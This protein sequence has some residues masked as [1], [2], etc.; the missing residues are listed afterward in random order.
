MKNVS[1]KSIRRLLGSSLKSENGAATVEFVLWVPVMA[2]LLGLVIDTSLVFGARSQI[3]R[4]VQDTNRAV[5]VGRIRS[6]AE[7]E[8]ILLLNIATIAPNALAETTMTAGII[9]STVTIPISD[10]T[11]TGL[12]NSFNGFVVTVTS[13]HLAES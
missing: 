1:V 4:V 12:V 11:A 6:P 13:Q 3:L 2:A 9:S 10:L 8:A 7:A 5:S